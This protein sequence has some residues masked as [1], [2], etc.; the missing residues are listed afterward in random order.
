MHS[1]KYFRFYFRHKRFCNEK[2]IEHRPLP[3]MHST[4]WSNQRSADT[5]VRIHV[6]VQS[7]VRVRSF[8]FVRDRT[9]VRVRRHRI[10]FVR[11]Q[12]ITD[13]FGPDRAVRRSFVVN[14]F[15]FCSFIFVYLFVIHVHTA[16]VTCS[17]LLKCQSSNDSGDCHSSFSEKHLL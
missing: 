12:S 16:M 17:L 2:L 8:D 7:R 3:S 4:L 14:I 13:Q 10:E 11:V 6:R 1:D 15:V 9:R 5:R